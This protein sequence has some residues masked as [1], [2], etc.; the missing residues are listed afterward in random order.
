MER[1]PG[2]GLRVHL[3]TNPLVWLP[4]IEELVLDTL[5]NSEGITSPDRFVA[6]V[7][8]DAIHL[9]VVHDGQ[10]VVGFYTTETLDTS[11]GPVC[12]VPFAGFRKNIAALLFAFKHAER[13]A[14]EAR[15]V[16]FKFISSDRRWG[17]LAKR[18]GYKP[19]FVEYWKEF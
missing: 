10:D 17:A 1:H 6:M 3:V 8:Q 7:L 16:G 14:R 13:V 5:V 9:W 4:Q 18:L 19:R 11:Q 2:E 15:Y 12:N